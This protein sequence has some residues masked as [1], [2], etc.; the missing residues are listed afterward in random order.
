MKIAVGLSG[1]VDSS[2]T[3]WLLKEQGHDVIGLTMAI[4]DGEDSVPAR[5]HACYGP[6]EKEEIQSAREFCHTIGIPFYAFDCAKEYRESVLS[7]FKMEY[8]SGRT[9]NPCVKCN[10]SMKF[11]LL[12]EKARNAGVD[13]DYFATGHYAKVVFAQETGRW[14]LLKGKDPQKD[15]SYFLYRLTQKQLSETMFPLGEMTKAGVRKIA[16]ENNFHTADMPASQDFYCGDYTDLLDFPQKD[17]DIIDKNGKILG[18]HQGIW[19]YT[20]GQRKRLGVFQ[21]RPLYVISTDS[22]RNT[23]TVA[24][25]NEAL[26]ISI[27]VANLNWIAIEKLESTF[28]FNIKIRSFQRSAEGL[29]EPREDARVKITFKEPQMA[30]APGQSAVFYSNDVVI[31]GGIIEKTVD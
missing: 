11:G 28:R 3:A 13:F 1:G 6:G 4:W 10:H 29:A 20:P 9:P 12:L 22:V 17:G 8:A 27:I 31:G 30:A 15:Q 5:K 26:S 7:Y 23:V 14:L 25:K 2:V 21:P 16:A 24:P 18:Q 19:N